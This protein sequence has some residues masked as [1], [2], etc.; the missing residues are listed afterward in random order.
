MG[1][2]YILISFMAVKVALSPS[3]RCLITSIFLQNNGPLHCVQT[4]V[5]EVLAL[6]TFCVVEEFGALVF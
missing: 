1:I 6:A 5:F 3:F 4:A 2:P